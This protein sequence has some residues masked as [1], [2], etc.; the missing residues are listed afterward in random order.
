MRPPAQIRPWLNET[1]LAAWV[2]DA[3]DRARYQRRL[4]IWLAHGGRFH[5][6]E[7]AEMLLVSKQA[8]WLWISE[9]NAQGPAGL[10]RSG[11]GG[12]RWSYLQLA[13]ERSFLKTLEA[14]ALKGEVLTVKQLLPELRKL[15]GRPVSLGFAYDLLRRHSWRKISPRPRHPKSDPAAQAE[16]K[17][18]FP[19]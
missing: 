5:A 12:R 15:A 1:E 9:Y 17:K 10:R 8:V 16:F 11:R 7:I 2:Q 14:R 4:A 19:R 3:E 13:K 6:R 18:N